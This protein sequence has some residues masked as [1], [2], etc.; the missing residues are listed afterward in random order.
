MYAFIIDGVPEDEHVTNPFVFITLNEFF[1][2]LF[3][4]LTQGVAC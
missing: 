4:I 1:F 2:L 3:L